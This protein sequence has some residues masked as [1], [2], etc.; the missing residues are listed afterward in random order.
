LGGGRIIPHNPDI[1]RSELI[2]ALVPGNAGIV[3]NVSLQI[4]RA[5]NVRRHGVLFWTPYF[6][7][8]SVFT[9]SRESAQ[10]GDHL[11]AIDPGRSVDQ[12]LLKQ[13]ADSVGRRL[14]QPAACQLA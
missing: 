12:S 14:V 4:G 2:L 7:A 3:G 9:V 10:T 5:S 1:P 11:A 6:D 13:L 8:V